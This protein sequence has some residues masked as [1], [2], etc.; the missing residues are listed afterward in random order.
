MVSASLSSAAVKSPVLIESPIDKAYTHVE[1]SNNKYKTVIIISY[2][3]YFYYLLVYRKRPKSVP[4]TSLWCTEI[5]LQNLRCTELD[6]RCTELDMYRSGIPR[7]TEMDMYRIGPT[8][9]SIGT[10]N[11]TEPKNPYD[12]L[13]GTGHTEWAHRMQDCT[14]TIV[15]TVLSESSVKLRVCVQT[16]NDI[17]C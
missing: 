1:I 5:A 17:H 13:S 8:P 11:N 10:E 9:P 2:S 15:N 14:C 16:F 12:E 7:C 3:H 6:H 4:K